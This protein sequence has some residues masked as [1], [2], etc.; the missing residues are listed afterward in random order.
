MR[1]LV[2]VVRELEWKEDAK[3]TGIGI[4]VRRTDPANGAQTD[5]LAV[6]LAAAG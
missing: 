3:R 1:A 2:Q 4:R 6:R 5:L